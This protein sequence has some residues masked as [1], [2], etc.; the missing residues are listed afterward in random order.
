MQYK[1]GVIIRPVI[2]GGFHVVPMTIRLSPVH[3]GSLRQMQPEGP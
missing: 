3:G 2:Y 1:H